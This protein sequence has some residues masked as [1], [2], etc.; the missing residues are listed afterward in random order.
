MEIKIDIM[1]NLMLLIQ[2]ASASS[3]FYLIGILFI[4]PNSIFVKELEKKGYD[5]EY[6]LNKG[7]RI[8]FV[9]WLISF[10]IITIL[11]FCYLNK[12]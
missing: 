3:L 1:E 4:F 8:V 12:T 9:I 2:C 6:I 10:I 5:Y 7:H 11:V